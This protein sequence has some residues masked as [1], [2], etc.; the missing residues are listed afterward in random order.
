MDDAMTDLAVAANA[1]A[2]TVRGD[3][4]RFLRVTTDSRDV[5]AGDLFVALKGERFDGHDFVAGAFQR[6]AAAALVAAD[7]ARQLQ[8][9]LLVAADP[10]EALAALAL[11]W[12]RRFTLPL[13]A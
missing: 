9:N 1:V 2:G 13:V 4:V 11:W 12:R 3:N 8:G 10:L 5:G 6:G 7:R